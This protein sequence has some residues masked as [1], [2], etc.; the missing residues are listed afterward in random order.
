MIGTKIKVFLLLKR[1]KENIR[2]LII[3]KPWPQIQVFDKKI[4]LIQ[5]N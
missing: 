2:N 3:M 1:S 4:E 5:I